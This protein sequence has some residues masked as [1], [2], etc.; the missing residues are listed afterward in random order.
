MLRYIE[1]QAPNRAV[2]GRTAVPNLAPGEALIET[3]QSRNYAGDGTATKD[4]PARGCHGGRVP[5]FR[6]ASLGNV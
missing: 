5:V 6:A 3:I 4:A 1:C 2:M